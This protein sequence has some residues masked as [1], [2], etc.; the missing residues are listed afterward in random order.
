MAKR[1]PIEVINK[2]RELRQR[3][4]SMPEIKAYTK[5]GYGTIFR[6]IKDVLILPKYRESWLVK[7]GG[8]R[9]RKLN[10]EIEAKQ[11]AKNIIDNLNSKEKIIFLSAL[12]WGEGSKGD[13][14]LIN[15]D[16]ELIG[17]FVRGLIDSFSVKKESIRVTVRIYEDL[18]EMRCLQFWSNVTTIPAQD[19]LNT[20]II[21]GKEF[22]KM[23]YGMCRIRV[24][25]G[26][27]LL[28]LVKAINKEIVSIFSPRSSMDRTGAS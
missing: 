28:K 23:P 20:E 1:I 21:K 18:D 26:G 9:K 14:C 10:K 13:F 3:G 17:T 16:P 25:K 19:F 11:N 22:G 5:I 8:S 27:D 15:G 2:A 24:S 6:Y 7:R 4:W 12:Y